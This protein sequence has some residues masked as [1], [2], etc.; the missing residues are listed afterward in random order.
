MTYSGGGTLVIG[1]NHAV[2]AAVLN[3]V[4]QRGRYGPPPPDLDSP[5]SAQ[6]PRS[7]HTLA[8]P[9]Q[10]GRHGRRDV[11]SRVRLRGPRAGDHHHPLRIPST[12]R[13]RARR[14]PALQR[15]ASGLIPLLVRRALTP[16][17]PGQATR[18]FSR[19]ARYRHRRLEP[20]AV[21][22]RLGARD[23]PLGRRRG[24]GPAR[25]PQTALG[26]SCCSAAS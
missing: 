2:L 24:A 9:S 11:S 13:K 7:T 4:A 17:D 23:G 20:T 10:G 18:L 5:R 26:I 3:R 16:T 14:I 25:R 8:H 1:A 19:W 21:G 6:Q 15:G 22:T 12:S